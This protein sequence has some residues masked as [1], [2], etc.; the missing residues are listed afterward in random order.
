MEI[1]LYQ[2][3]DTDLTPLLICLQTETENPAPTSIPAEI[4]DYED[5]FHKSSANTLHPHFSTDIHIAL[6]NNKTLSKCLLYSMSE[7]EL[8]L[9]KK[10]IDDNLIKGFIHLSKS[11]FTS[12][13]L[14]ADKKKGDKRFCVDYCKLNTITV[15][16]QYAIPLIS[17]LLE[18]LGVVK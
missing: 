14:F 17:D 6:M 15:K 9:L 2:S 3:D 10:Y 18:Q 13:V 4:A 11:L 7:L 8:Y 1:N 5:V 12:S 16:N